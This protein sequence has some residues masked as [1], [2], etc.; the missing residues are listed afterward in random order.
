MSEQKTWK[1]RPTVYRG[2]EMRSRTEAR[3]AAVLDRVGY[4][5]DYEPR[6]YGSMRG[7]WLPDFELTNGVPGHRSFVEV[8]PT[9]DA[10]YAAIPKVR[11]VFASEPDASVI[12]TWPEPDGP[13]KILKVSPESAWEPYS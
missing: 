6:A 11:V 7:Q 2:V 8:K 10:A 3:F 12:V 9:R 4:T 5:W 1:A 13:F